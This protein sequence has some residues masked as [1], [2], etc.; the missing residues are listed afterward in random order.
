MIKTAIFIFQL[1]YLVVCWSQS[2]SAHLSVFST[3]QNITVRLNSIILG[4]T[5]LQDIY[6]EPGKYQIEAIVTK[7]GIWYNHN[8]VK[9]IQLRAGQDT[10]IYFQIPSL[11]KI[12]SIPFHAR[13]L[14]ENHFIGLTPL[15]ID[16]NQFQG[17]E[18]S[19]EKTGFKSVRFV[20][21]SDRPQVYTLDP[22]VLA[23]SSEEHHSFLNSLFRSRLKTKFILLGGTVAS[24]WLAFYFKNLAD[25][26]YNSYLKTGNPQQMQKYWDN[27]QKYDRWSDISIAVSYTFLGGLIYTVLLD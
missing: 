12:N 22:I 1:S 14:Q 3:P 18:L 8:I 15:F 20:L 25:V 10:T 7:P 21:S 4:T 13:L 17:K 23:V 24:H 16:F 19:L 9:E 11:V 5:P 2:E 26:N 6:V 27:T